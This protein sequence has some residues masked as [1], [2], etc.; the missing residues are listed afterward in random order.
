MATKL[1]TTDPV[2]IGT[3]LIQSS[4]SAGMLYIEAIQLKETLKQPEANLEPI[5][6][7]LTKMKMEKMNCS[8][9]VEQT[10]KVQ[11]TAGKVLE[12]QAVV[13][14]GKFDHC[15]DTVGYPMFDEMIQQQLDSLK[16]LFKTTMVHLE[17]FRAFRRQIDRGEATG[18]LEKFKERLAVV[19]TLSERCCIEFTEQ[20][21][22]EIDKVCALHARLKLLLLSRCQSDVVKLLHRLDALCETGMPPEVERQRKIKAELNTAIFQLQPKWRDSIDKWVCTLGHASKPEKGWG[23]LH[24]YDD[25]NRLRLACHSAIM[26]SVLAALPKSI[27]FTTPEEQSLF[28]QTMHQVAMGPKAASPKD[29]AENEL[30]YLFDL[31]PEVIEELKKKKKT[32]LVDLSEIFIHANVGHLKLLD[33]LEDQILEIKSQLESV[34]MPPDKAAI[35]KAIQE[36]LPVTLR[37][38]LFLLVSEN[39]SIDQHENKRHSEEHYADDIPELIASIRLLKE[40]EQWGKEHCA[41][42]IPRLLHAIRLLKERASHYGSPGK[43]N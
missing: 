43:H 34:C 36:C 18:A 5:I 16:V 10:K 15:F 41:D 29:W 1:M 35:Q 42:D 2:A 14:E 26:E 7:L 6:N 24:R 30:P 21:Q 39:H 37:R 13:L 25:L 40:D 8:I 33:E 23:R 17:A 27:N 38:D 28:F 22:E 3:E 9:L 31:I 32:T 19:S 12:E 11:E 4:F 20:Q